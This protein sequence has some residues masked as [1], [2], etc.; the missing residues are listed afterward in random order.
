MT[1]LSPPKK[2]LKSVSAKCLSLKGKQT[3]G[4]F[5]LTAWIRQST[6]K[7]SRYGQSKEK[8]YTINRRFAVGLSVFNYIPSYGILNTMPF[9]LLVSTLSS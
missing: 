4:S 2:E 5:K 7:H 8:K 9:K 3:L 6:L 1:E